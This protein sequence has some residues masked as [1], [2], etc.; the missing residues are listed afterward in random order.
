ML[1]PVPSLSQSKDSQQNVVLRDSE[2]ESILRYSLRAMGGRVPADSTATGAV[3][4]TE[5]GTVEEGTIRIL[6]K[7]VNQSAEELHLPSDF[8]SLSFSA[9]GGWEK[10]HSKAS[11]LSLQRAIRSD[12]MDFPMS[13]VAAVLGNTEIKVEYLGEETV[14]GVLSHHIRYQ[15]MFLLQ[16][17][18]KHLEESSRVELWVE[19]KSSLPRL[20]TFNQRDSDGESPQI[21]MAISYSDYRDVGGILYPF[22]I[23]KQLNGMPWATVN[24]DSVTLNSGLS[25]SEFTSHEE[26]Q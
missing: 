8:R 4:L 22:S 13:I 5:G 24:I 3:R 23:T 1:N 11:R 26:L 9:V 10:R 21:P 12:T 2:A 19:A 20:I 14:E 6:T 7:G 25:D 16:P 18:L 15:R 17:E